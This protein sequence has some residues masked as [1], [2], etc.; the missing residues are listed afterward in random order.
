MRYLMTLDVPSEINRLTKEY[1][2][3]VE[4]YI[5]SG[6][7]NKLREKSKSK[8]EDALKVFLFNCVTCSKTTSILSVSLRESTYSKPL[9]RNGRTGRK[10]LSYTYTKAVIDFFSSRGYI[11]LDLGGVVSWERDRHF[12][13]EVIE[14]KFTPKKKPST[15]KL[16]GEFKEKCT[17][18][19]IGLNKLINKDVVHLRGEDKQTLTYSKRM[20]EDS[21]EK[22]TELNERA[23]GS[24]ITVGTK[25]ITSCAQFRKIFNKDFEHGGRIY[26][27][28]IQ[29]LNG[30][31]RKNIKIDGESTVQ[32]DFKAFETSLA[33]SLCGETLTEDP[34]S[35][36]LEGYDPKVMRDIC[37]AIMTRI[38]YAGSKSSVIHSMTDWVSKYTNESKLYE[39]GK[40]PLK[41]IPVAA[42]VESL[43]KKHEKV[44]S[45][46]FRKGDKDLQN[47]GAQIIDYVV[48]SALEHYNE[49]VLPV[50]DEVICCETISEEIYGLMAQGFDKIVGSVMNCRIEKLD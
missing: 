7:K 34:Y 33:Y 31:A 42:F 26:D 17:S 35:C 1:L 27:R 32:F 47:V 23:C 50:F 11:D 15:V 38:Y 30:R 21:I 3:L 29:C 14:Y 2:G 48:F 12:R 39:D 46:M 24:T 41:Y 37:K 49:L 6:K 36:D 13:E 8:L 40:I 18:L 5:V 9:V 22:L 45:Y 16:V 43:M 4:E 20:A 25:E 44:S 10:K 19:A 28:G